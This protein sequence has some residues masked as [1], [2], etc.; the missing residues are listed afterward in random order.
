[1]E[2]LALGLQSSHIEARSEH[3]AQSQLR[4]GYREGR[5]WTNLGAKGYKQRLLTAGQG[6]YLLC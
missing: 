3:L 6:S 1:M 5:M 2:P 4:H